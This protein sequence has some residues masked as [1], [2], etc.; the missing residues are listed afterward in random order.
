MTRRDQELR[1]IASVLPDRA[2]NHGRR[3]TDVIVGDAMIEP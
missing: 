3:L 2:N 1:F